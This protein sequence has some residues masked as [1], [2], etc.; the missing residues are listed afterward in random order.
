MSVPMPETAESRVLLERVATQVQMHIDN[1]NRM[2]GEI[3][4]SLKNI[5]QANQALSE[6][7]DR[8]IAR[9]HDQGEVAVAKMAL[10]VAAAHSHAQSA[11]DEIKTEKIKLLTSVVLYI[12]SLGGVITWKAKGG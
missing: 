6:K 3:T 11:H 7:F 2:F 8:A 1:D 10:S 9:V 5:Q 12:I 4:H